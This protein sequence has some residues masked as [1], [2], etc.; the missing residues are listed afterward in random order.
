MRFP[1]RETLIVLHLYVA[2]TGSSFGGGKGLIRHPEWGA[3]SRQARVFTPE[4]NSEMMIGLT[5]ESSSSE[6]MKSPHRTPA[7]T[8]WLSG[9]NLPFVTYT[10]AF[11]TA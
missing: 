6:T 9:I 3:F 5:H 11:D 7:C 8:D 10:N 2:S 1:G 4:E